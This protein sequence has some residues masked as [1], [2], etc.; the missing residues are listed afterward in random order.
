MNDKYDELAI[1]CLGA[2]RANN[3]TRILAE[4][5]HWYDKQREQETCETCAVNPQCDRLE[6][7]LVI[8]DFEPSEWRCKYWEP[9]RRIVEKGS[10]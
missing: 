5:F 7:A 1:R 9:K 6:D 4:R 3:Y 10:K 8:A 2:E